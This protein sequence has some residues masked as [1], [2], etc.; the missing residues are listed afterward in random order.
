MDEESRERIELKIAYLESA[1]QALSAVVYRQ[2]RELDVLRERVGMVAER[3]ESL[4][5]VA[6]GE[7]SVLDPAAERPPHY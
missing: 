7:D 4:L 6:T 3:L 1:N 5:T 2:Q